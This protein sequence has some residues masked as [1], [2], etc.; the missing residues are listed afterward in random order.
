MRLTIKIKLI[1]AFASV[2]ALTALLGWFAVGRTAEMSTDNQVLG[3]KAIPAARAVGELKNQTGKF[4]RDQLRYATALTADD[5]TG[6]AEDLAEDIDTIAGITKNYE[7]KLIT[8]DADQRAL[9]AFGAGWQEYV[10]NTAAVQP[11]TDAGRP[12]NAIAA[13][14][15]GAGDKAWDGLKEDLALLD[16]VSTDFAREHVAEVQADAAS[17][18]TIALVLLGLALAISSLVAFLLVRSLSGG[19]KRLVAAAHGIAEGD[20]NQSIEETSPRTRSATTAAAC[21]RMVEYLRGMAGAADRVA[22]GDLT[23]PRSSPARTATR[24]GTSLR[25]DGR[26]A[27]DAIVG[28]R[29][30]GAAR[31]PHSSQEMAS[32]SDEAGRAVGEIA[33]AVGEVAQGAERQVR[34]VEQRRAAPALRS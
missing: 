8:S 16:K 13:I 29:A 6:V 10:D 33:A 3:D 30:G 24:S 23:V 34:A 17:T 32:T 12:Q 31:W 27:C 2:L 19:L 28:A 25:R 9:A 11:E 1:A 5:R 21:G 20:L 18:R 22:D 4:R 26:R 15:E 7:A 14:N